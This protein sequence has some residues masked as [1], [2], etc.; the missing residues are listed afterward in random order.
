MTSVSDHKS[1]HYTNVDA[2]LTLQALSFINF[3][4]LHQCCVKQPNISL[5]KKTLLLWNY[6]SSTSCK[7]N[8]TDMYKLNQN[9]DN[10]FCQKVI[11]TSIHASSKSDSE[12]TYLAIMVCKTDNFA[13]S[14]NICKLQKCT[15][16]FTSNSI[17]D[18]IIYSHHF[19]I[20]AYYYHF[21]FIY[22]HSLY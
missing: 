7:I 22:P 16:K 12:S 8:L 9:L 21:S 17:F 11:P 14:A 6:N 13:T 4:T 2:K 3:H 10:N 18:V 15:K 5:P 20:T 19:T 1:C